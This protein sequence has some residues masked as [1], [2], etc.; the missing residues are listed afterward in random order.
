MNRKQKE[1]AKALKD[2]ADKFRKHIDVSA[3]N[4]E[5]N[6]EHGKPGGIIDTLKSVSR[7]MSGLLR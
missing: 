4:A 1:I 7:R 2:L 6:E 5:F 3:G